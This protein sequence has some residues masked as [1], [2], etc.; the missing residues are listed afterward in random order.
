VTPGVGNSW[1]QNRLTEVG[2]YGVNSESAYGTN[3]QAGILFEW[4]DAVIGSRR[5]LR[6][7]SWLDDSSN[8]P[9]ALSEDASPAEELRVVGFRVASVPEPSAV[10]MTLIAASVS[11]TRRRRSSL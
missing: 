2:A 9:A 1:S 7:G 4:N 5:V 6:G 8:L 11:L 3:D 10:L